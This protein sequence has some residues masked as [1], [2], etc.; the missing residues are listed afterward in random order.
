[1][2]LKQLLLAFLMII[3]ALS[4]CKS[5]P[6]ISAEEQ[7]AA[8]EVRIKEFITANNIPAVRHQSGL[9]YQIIEPGTGN[10]VYNA[11]TSITAEYS[12]RLLNGNTVPQPAGPINFSLGGVIIGW[13]IGIPLIQKGGKIRLFVPSGYAYGS[14]SRNGIPANSVLDFDVELVDAQN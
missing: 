9:Y 1:M 14:Q 11:N 7:L 10:L 3:T 6:G 12:L 13:Q 4:A 2:K 5:D 8:D